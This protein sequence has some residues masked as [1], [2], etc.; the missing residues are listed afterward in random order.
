MKPD[1]FLLHRNLADIEHRVEV[2]HGFFL[3]K[4]GIEYRKQVTSTLD[5]LRLPFENL[6][7]IQRVSRLHQRSSYVA[8]Y[9]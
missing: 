5:R 7:K 3:V 9:R 1:W 8:S 4:T 6:S 2:S